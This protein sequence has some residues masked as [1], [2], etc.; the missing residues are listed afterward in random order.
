MFV[1]HIADS[2]ASTMDVINV[3]VILASLR[4][5]LVIDD[6]LVLLGLQQV[7]KLKQL[8]NRVEKDD[9]LGLRLYL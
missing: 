7:V 3:D 6:K 8:R 1:T 2:S 9:D 4:G 5:T